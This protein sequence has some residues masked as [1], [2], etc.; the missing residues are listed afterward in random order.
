MIEYWELPTVI[1]M[2]SLNSENRKKQKWRHRMGPINFGRV[3]MA[4]RATKEN[5]EEPSKVE[6]F[7]AT[8]TKNGKQVDPET[9]VVIAELQNRQHLGETTDDSFKAVFGNEHP[10]QVRCYGRSVT[11]TSL[12]K[13]EEIIK[14]KQKHADEINSFKEEVK[15]LKE[16]VVELT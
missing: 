9:E 2:C 12:K 3:R 16:E 1:A 8:R 15:E 10:G 7:I 13:D 6:M 14:I 5:N 4:L 11:R